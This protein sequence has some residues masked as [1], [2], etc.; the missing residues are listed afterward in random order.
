MS[1]IAGRRNPER[2]RGAGTVLVVGLC[3][4]ALALLGVLVLLGQAAAAQARAATGADLAALAAADIA[5]GL[6]AGD[7]CAAAGSIAAANRVRVAGCRI[8][9][10]RGGTAEIVV[11]APMPYPWPAATGRARAGAPP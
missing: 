3:A 4:V 1:A 9:D 5:R 2:E 8:T 7:P 6:R 10:E 11:T